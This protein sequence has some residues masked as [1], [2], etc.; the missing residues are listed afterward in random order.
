MK[1]P[2][3]LKD[4]EINLKELKEQCQ[5]YIDYIDD[6][7]KY[8]EDNDNAHYVFEKAMETLFGKDVWKFINERQP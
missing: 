4:E 6:D 5:S 3:L 8:S 7:E 2:I 1:K